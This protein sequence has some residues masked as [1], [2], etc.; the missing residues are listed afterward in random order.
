MSDSNRNKIIVALDVPNAGEARRHID[1]LRDSVGGF[2]IGL[3]LF[4]AEGPQFV[5][6]V[7]KDGTKLFLDVKFHDIPAT[8]AKAAVEVTRLGVWMF[9]IHSVGG[10][11]MIK[12]T[13][14]SVGEVC[15]KE[16]LPTPIII[17]VTV[18]TS[19]DQAMLANLGIERE[20]EEQ[21]R[22]LAELSHSSGLDGVVAS[23]RETPL[24]R[25][26][27]TDRDFLVV[28][29]GIRSET[30]ENDDQ[31]RTA[32][33]AEAVLAGSDYLV[34]GR[35]ILQSADKAKAVDKIVKGIQT[36]E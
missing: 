13:V 10:H 4:S 27:V 35:P 34:I 26:Q 28:T 32:T 5:R 17:G 23:P 14:E 7:V 22:H 8:V 19:T 25:E 11:E 33:P 9:N 3:Q 18:L 2:K 1:E 30:V 36:A 29:P 16:D 20:V 31:K 15:E 21:V 12:R 24:I 6:E